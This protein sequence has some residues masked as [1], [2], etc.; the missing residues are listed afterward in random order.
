MFAKLILLKNL[1]LREM[2]AQYDETKHWKVIKSPKKYLLYC[3]IPPSYLIKNYA[4]CRDIN[5]ISGSICVPSFY[6]HLK[7]C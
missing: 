2:H 1:G 7:W 6:L 3:W 5:N 4:V